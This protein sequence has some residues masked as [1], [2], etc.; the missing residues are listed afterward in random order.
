MLI[1]ELIKKRV[2]NKEKATSLEYKAKT[3]GKTEEEII[4]EEKI[5]V[6]FYEYNTSFINRYFYQIPTQTYL[7]NIC[8]QLALTSVNFIN[9][10]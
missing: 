5:Y 8:Q 10:H 7:L 3:S 9:L 2:L 1:Q 4:L 6:K